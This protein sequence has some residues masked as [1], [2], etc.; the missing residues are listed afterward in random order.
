LISSVILTGRA[1]WTGSLPNLLRTP[2]NESNLY[3]I[4]KYLR[5][6]IDKKHCYLEKIFI[7]KVYR[8]LP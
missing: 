7:E 5:T 4:S 2:P 3:S 6:E 8:F 1:M